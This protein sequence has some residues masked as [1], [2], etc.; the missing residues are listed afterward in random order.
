MSFAPSRSK[1][2]LEG[3]RSNVSPDGHAPR[4]GL[5][6]RNRPDQ[7]I[8]TACPAESPAARPRAWG[9]RWRA[10][11]PASEAQARCPPRAGAEPSPPAGCMVWAS[12]AA[13]R[14][15]LTGGNGV[16]TPAWFRFDRC[17]LALP[18]SPAPPACAPGLGTATLLRF[19]NSG[20]NRDTGSVSRIEPF[21][22][23]SINT[24]VLGHL[25]GHRW[26]PEDA[27]FRHRLL[28]DWMSIWPCASNGATRPLRATSVT[29]PESPLSERCG[30]RQ[31]F[32]HA[33]PDAS[34]R[35][36]DPGVSASSEQGAISLLCQTEEQSGVTLHRFRSQP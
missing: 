33:M 16:S 35:K 9:C 24:A 14:D 13:N 7:G 10:C 19:L 2:P 31:W 6:T 8:A 3:N 25:A 27:V 1:D 12:M 22:I 18:R 34:G 36:P 32:S 26:G 21:Q 11:R 30:I 29:T 15:R 4:P 20:M 28:L 5:R 17:R 23:S